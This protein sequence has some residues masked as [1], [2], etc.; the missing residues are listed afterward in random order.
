M[1]DRD[2]FAAAALTGL[3]SGKGLQYTADD[4]GT[5]CSAAW[6][7]ADAMLAARGDTD[8]DA[9]PAAT[10]SDTENQAGGRRAATSAGECFDRLCDVVD[11]IVGSYAAPP[12][13]SVT[14]TD[15]ER[16]ELDAAASEYEHGAEKIVYGRPAHRRR[17]ATIRGLLARSGGQTSGQDPLGQS[18]S[19][20]E[21]TSAC[22]ATEPANRAAT[23]TDSEREAL[24]RAANWLCQAADDE[25]SFEC[26]AT[27]RGLLARATK[28]GR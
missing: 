3:L 9:A 26:A 5:F 16:R 2:H 27:I 24:E 14:L 1:T 12:A 6:A 21:N 19:T 4:R 23:L 11:E 22:S 15:A 18:Q 13:S 7:L 10:A 25:R 17:A 20:P 28:E 8:L